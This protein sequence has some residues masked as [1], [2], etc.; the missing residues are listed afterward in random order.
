MFK[1][2][3][4]TLPCERQ[5]RRAG[6][7]CDP[8]GRGGGGTH[9]RNGAYV[10]EARARLSSFYL[11]AQIVRGRPAEAGDDS[12]VSSVADAPGRPQVADQSAWC[13]E[14]VQ[15][16]WSS[17]LRRP[18]YPGHA[19][20]MPTVAAGCSPSPFQNEAYLHSHPVLIN[21]AVFHARLL[22]DHVQTS[23]PTQCPVCAFKALLDCGIE[24]GR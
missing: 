5:I 15:Q 6:R 16:H 3:G 7:I 10:D 23:D 9:P 17:V 2:V 4:I 18:V 21:L 13:Q 12:K 11:S 22:L 1:R 20:P 14:A 8:H 24:A 19:E